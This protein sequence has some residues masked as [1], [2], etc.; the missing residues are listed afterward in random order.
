MKLRDILSF[1]AD[2]VPDSLLHILALEVGAYIPGQ[3]QTGRL[4]FS[5]DSWHEKSGS[6]YLPWL[7][8]F[9]IIIEK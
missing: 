6:D 1:D 4:H 5:I 2:L 8:W 7:G 9:V 3:P